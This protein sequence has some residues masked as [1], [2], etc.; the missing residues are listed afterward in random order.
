M[1]ITD[2]ERERRGR[3]GGNASVLFYDFL[4]SYDQKM[5][6]VLYGAGHLGKLVYRIL[7]DW[8]IPVECFCESVR[9]CDSACGLPVISAETL[10]KEYQGAF[11][12]V[13]IGSREPRLGV[14]RFLLNNGFDSASIVSTFSSSDQYFGYSFFPPVHDEIYVDVG[15]DDGNT[16]IDYNNISHGHYRK[17]IALEPDAINVKRINENINNR[18]I[19]RLRLIPKGAW[20]SNT[21]ISFENLGNGSSKISDKGQIMAPVIKLDDVLKNVSGDIA[22]KMDIEGA[23]LEALKGAKETIIQNKPRLAICVYHKPEDII[24]IPLYISEIAPEYKFFIRHNCLVN[25][26]ETVLYAVA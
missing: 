26:T 12:V 8:N 22:I 13:C 11:V 4:L 24:D 2:F 3:I 18:N 1:E 20:S 21:K 25:L 19:E 7:K 17:I 10:I 6:V 9:V 15:S 14:Y 23:E 5:K 16:I